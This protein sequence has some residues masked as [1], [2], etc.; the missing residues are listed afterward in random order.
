MEQ[1]SDGL[2]VLLQRGQAGRGAE[3][4]S[5][6]QLSGL[7][8]VRQDCGAVS[9][10]VEESSVI[11]PIFSHFHRLQVRILSGVADSMRSRKERSTPMV[12]R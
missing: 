4:G 8:G 10:S 12:L 7:S 11:S 1:W 3:A 9:M 6:M 5:R 2:G